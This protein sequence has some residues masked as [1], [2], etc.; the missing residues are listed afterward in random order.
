MAR[1]LDAAIGGPRGVAVGR[2]PDRWN[3]RTRINSNGGFT[4]FLD[5]TQI[6][7]SGQAPTSLDT[8]WTFPAAFSTTTNLMLFGAG[9]TSTDASFVSF[10]APTTSQVAFNHWSHDGTRLSG[11]G[12]SIMAIGRWF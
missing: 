8:V 11:L 1:D 6:C 3:R 12:C 9:R 4:R 5:G 7:W 10:R 2:R